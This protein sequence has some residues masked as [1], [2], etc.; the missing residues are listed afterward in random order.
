[1]VIAQSYIL[2]NQ[3]FGWGSHLLSL[4]K[5]ENTT[6]AVHA[7]DKA[8]WTTPLPAKCLENKQAFICQ[9]QGKARL[10]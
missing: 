10:G 7:M 5:A 8:E 3:E 1:M 4:S 9:L 2:A 6:G